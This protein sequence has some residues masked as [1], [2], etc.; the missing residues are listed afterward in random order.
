MASARG[1]V[2]RVEGALERAAELAH[3]GAVWEL[4]AEGARERAALLAARAARGED[5]GQLAGTIC[6]WK[7]CYDVA[8]LH[9]TGGAPWRAVAPPVASSATVVRRL[10][11]AGAITIGKLAMTQLAWGMMGQ[12]PGR[13]ICHNPHDPTRVPGGSSSGSAVAV[14]TRIVDH[15]PGTDSGGSVRHP[16][17]ACGVVGFK[18]TYGS[19]PLDGCMPYAPSF[20]TGGA[21]ARTVAE[22]ARQYAAIAAVAPVDLAGGL[23]GLRVAFLGGYFTAALEQDVATM[24]ERARGRV[25]AQEIDIAWSQDDNRA[26]SPIFTAEPGAFALEHDPDPDPARYDPTTFA[27]VERSR[28]LLALD[29]VRGRAALAEAQRRCA[30]AAAGYDILLCASAPCPPVPIDGPDKTTR[31]NALTK[32]FN[33]LGWPAVSVPAGRDRDGLP[34]GLQVVGL[35]A[36]DAVVLRAAAA[37][38]GLLQD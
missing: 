34:L 24:L 3:L 11:A 5:A 13:P 1:I 35:P 20:D 18:P 14:A 33:G 30:A 26:M 7:D 27:D 22:A 19:L 9:T 16:A 17:A 28:T 8:G 4:D 29:Y 21:I 10:E 37:L 25:R 38:E 36:S 32:P 12:T 23:A 6:G 2:E 31:M 15:A